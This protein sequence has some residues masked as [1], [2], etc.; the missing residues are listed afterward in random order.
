MWVQ[1][2]QNNSLAWSRFVFTHFHDTILVLMFTLPFKKLGKGDA[3]QAGGK[4]ASLGE[5]TQAGI[6]VPPEEEISCEVLN[7]IAGTS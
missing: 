6:P 2:N 1:R 4:G 3:S 7:G 5:M